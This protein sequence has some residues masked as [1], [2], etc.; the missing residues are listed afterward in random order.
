[1]NLFYIVAN[2]ALGVHLWHGGW[3][4]FQS[5]GWN[6]PRFNQARRWFALG[7]A[8]IVVAGN[9]SFAVAVLA[10]VISV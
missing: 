1:M 4:L 8:G 3:S 5:L 6:N 7:F 2:L 10:G 9:V